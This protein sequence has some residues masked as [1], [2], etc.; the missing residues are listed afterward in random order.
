MKIRSCDDRSNLSVISYIKK[1]LNKNLCISEIIILPTFGT[2]ALKHD[3]STEVAFYRW[4]CY[5]F[6]QYT[7]SSG[8]V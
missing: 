4:A 3:L 1:A 2:C 5:Y 7:G 8:E 6:I